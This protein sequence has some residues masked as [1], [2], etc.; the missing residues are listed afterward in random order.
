M[1]P[2]GRIGSRVLYYVSMMAFRG[3]IPKIVVV[4]GILSCEIGG[5]CCGSGAGCMREKCDL[6]SLIDISKIQS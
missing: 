5:S 4:S 6:R 2:C 1:C 3:S